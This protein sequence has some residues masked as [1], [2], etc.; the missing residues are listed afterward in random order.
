ML[1]IVTVLYNQENLLDDFFESIN[2]QNIKEFKIYFIDNSSNRNA[3]E[4]TFELN[5][6]Y[7][8]NIDLIYNNNNLGVAGGNNIGIR[9]AISDGCDFVL[10]SNYDINIKK[11][12]VVNDLLKLAYRDNSKIYVPKIYYYGTNIIWYGGGYIDYIRGITVHNGDNENDR[13]QCDAIGL[14]NYAPTCFMI[15]HKNIFE[16]VGLMDDKYFVYFDD[17]DFVERCTKKGVRIFYDPNIIIDHKVSQTT[18]GNWSEFSIRLLN[19][20]RIYFLRKNKN[21]F[22]ASVCTIYLTLFFFKHIK[23][24]WNIKNKYF[25]AIVDGWKL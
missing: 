20:N 18:G 8:F 24:L 17:T 10:L 9:R 6:K 1:G 19:R 21:K 16:N 23:V 15:I 22:Y 3:Y 2:N 11:T 4:K 5:K 25:I 14:T 12:N 13:G 7:G